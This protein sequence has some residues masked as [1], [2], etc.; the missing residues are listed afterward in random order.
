MTT[1]AASSHRLCFLY[2]SV[3]AQSQDASCVGTIVKA[4]RQFNAS[5]GLSGL[6]V[7]DGMRFFQYLE[8]PADALQAL[9][10]RLQQDPRH[11][12]F[13]TVWMAQLQ[14]ERRFP[15][16]SMGYAYADEDDPLTALAAQNG[17]EALDAFLAMTELLDM[18]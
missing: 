3:L 6:L 15:G 10:E 17:A 11:T 2:H 16:W 12:Q 7:F 9:I 14:G 18:A 13:T 8:G 5:Q 4:A 1:P